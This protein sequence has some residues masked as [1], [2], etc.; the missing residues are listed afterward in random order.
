[1]TTETITE[2]TPEDLARRALDFPR[3]TLGELAQEIGASRPALAAYRA[4]DR[5]LPP[6]VAHALA[7]WLRRH[8]TDAL[9]LADEL[10]RS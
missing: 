3:V 1:M 10:A 8:A 7:R 6:E 9:D 5:T 2:T 4:G